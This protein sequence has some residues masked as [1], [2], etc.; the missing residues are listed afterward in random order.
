MGVPIT[1]LDVYNPDQFEILDANEYRISNNVPVKAHG[2]VK[3]KEAAISG[4]PTYV[5][6]LIKHKI[7]SK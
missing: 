2:L 4:R 3:D 5:R 6:I 7:K 1:F